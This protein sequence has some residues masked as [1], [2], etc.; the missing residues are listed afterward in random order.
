MGYDAQLVFGRGNRIG[1]V[2]KGNFC[3]GVHDEGNF[4][5][6]NLRGPWWNYCPGVYRYPRINT[7]PWLCFAPPWLTRRQTD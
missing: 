3:Q 2:F 1:K 6:G 7:S 5:H 4:S